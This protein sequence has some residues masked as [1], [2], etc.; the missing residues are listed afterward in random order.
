MVGL[1]TIQVVQVFFFV[2]MVVKGRATALVGSLNM[3]KY[4]NGYDDGELFFGA[5]SE[6]GTI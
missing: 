2:R 6:V 5:K 3:L 1:E 4:A